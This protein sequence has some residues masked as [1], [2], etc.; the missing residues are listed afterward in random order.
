MPARILLGALRVLLVDIPSQGKGKA[1]ARCTKL[2]QGTYVSPVDTGS[3]LM[4]VKHNH[5]R[6]RASLALQASLGLL[7]QMDWLKRQ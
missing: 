1:M 6:V 3:T 2:L 4:Q 7:D 5:Q